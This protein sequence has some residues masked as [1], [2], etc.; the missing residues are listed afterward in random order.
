M[1]GSK[2]LRANPD[3]IDVVLTMKAPTTVKGIQSLNGRL[4]ALH[5]FLSKAADRDLPFMDVLRKSFKSEFKWTEEAARA[6]E[7]LKTCLGTLPMLTVPE[8]DEVLTVYLAASHGAISAVLVA[9]RTGAQIPIYYVSRTLKDYETRYSSLEKLALAL[10]HASRRLR[11][12]FQ[13]HPIEVRTDQRIQHVLRRPEVSGRMAKWAIELGAFNII[14][15]TKGP[16]KGQVV[17]DFLVGTPEEK[18]VKEAEKA[19]VKPWTLY[20]DGASSSEG[21]GA[22]FKSS[23]NEAEYKALLAG[24]RLAE[25]VGARDVIA[26]VDSLLVANQVNGVYEAREAN[27]IGYLEQVKQVMA[28]FDSCKVEHVTRSKNKKAD[29][30]SKLASVSF[31]HLAKEVRVEVLTAPS[32][33]APH[34]MQVEAPAQTWM[35]PL[36]NYL[37]HDV[38]PVDKAEAR[39]IQINSLQYQMQEGGLYRKTFLGPLLKCLDPEQASYIIRE[40]HYGICGIHAGP[41][42]IV[43]KV[44]NAG[45]YWPGMH[46]SAV[47]E[48]QQCDEC[49]R[50]APISLRAKNE[51]IPVTATWP[52]QKWGVDIVG[53]FPRSSGSAQYL[54]I[55]VDYFTK[56][57]EARPFIVI[58]GYNVAR[59]FW[60][61]I[62]NGQ[63]EQINRRIV[64]GIK[65]RL[66]YEGKGWADELPNVL[67]AH[68][69]LH[70][71]SNGETP[72]SLTYGTEA[73]IPAEIGLPNQRCKNWEENEHELR[74]N[75]D[76][77]EERRNIAAIKEARYK[78]KIEKYYN[79]RAKLYKFKVGDYV[80][81][82]NDASRVEARG[83]LAPKWEG[84]YRIKE[85][86][87]KGS[88]VLE[89][90]DGTPVPR[91]WNG[92]HLKKCFM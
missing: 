24:L 22:E 91:T 7:E 45:Y 9:H 16:L 57:V 58:S 63:V 31:S 21:S 50:H 19:P 40:I 66:G 61:Q 87:D 65:R 55:A 36:I 79:A 17:A 47:K 28:L 89:K 88:Y 52:F 18:V 15:R 1:V 32:I 74:S 38:L 3:K 42:M 30:L 14:F 53:P 29:A 67:W 20:T 71:T 60:E 27:M 6:F 54:L 73:V 59:F 78:K 33:S 10:V 80:L 62:G 37:V 12:Y 39:K 26:H 83:K 81:Q 68:R 25:K 76:L 75:L 8:K 70:K 56:W 86:S 35:T 44:K 46:E 72:F 41:K 92:V 48:L 5:W 82:N 4:A 2:G 69:T 85:A 23:N 90:I 11:R 34:V 51:M 49:Q 43:T 13:A 84:P 77:L 64:D